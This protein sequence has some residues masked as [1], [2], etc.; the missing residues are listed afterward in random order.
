MATWHQ[1]QN[2]SGHAALYTA[3]AKG[4]RVVID[5]P[6]QFAS[7]VDFTTKRAAQ[8]YARRSGGII[9]SAKATKEGGP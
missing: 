2:R 3:P 5:P 7:S 4:Y 6:G 8:R 9:I 1:Q